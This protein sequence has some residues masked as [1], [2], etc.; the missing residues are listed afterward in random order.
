MP[1]NVAKTDPSNRKTPQKVCGLT[2]FCRDETGGESPPKNRARNDLLQ[3]TAAKS[4]F[5]FESP[6]Q[7]EEWDWIGRF[8]PSTEV[9][10]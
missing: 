5:R 2:I 1:A 9:D 6:W 7:I 3:T 8:R 10:E 4:L